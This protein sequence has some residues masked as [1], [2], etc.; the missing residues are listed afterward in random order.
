MTTHITPHFT[1]AESTRT[2]T[3]AANTIA[4]QEHRER[5][6]HTAHQ[7]EIVRAVLL[8][9]PIT[10]NSWYRSP[11]VNRAVGGSATS[12]H[13]LGAAVD[14]VCPAFGI[15][16]RICQSLVQHAH[17]LNYNQL[18]YEGAWVHI[19]FPPDGVKGKNQVL[20][21]KNRVYHKGLVP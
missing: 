16:Y 7:M 4:S 19:S 12:E 5:I 20:T 15:P 13:P 2:S 9:N 3:G 21:Y 18:I 1:W 14:F 8:R 17:I 10:I 11:A 6:T